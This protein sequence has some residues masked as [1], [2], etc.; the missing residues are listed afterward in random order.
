MLCSSFNSNVLY[1]KD[2]VKSETWKLCKYLCSPL[3][4]TLLG[5]R[6][7]GE[8]GFSKLSSTCTLWTEKSARPLGLKSVIVF[9]WHLHRCFSWALTFALLPTGEAKGTL[10]FPKFGMLSKK[11]N[12]LFYWRMPFLASSLR[13]KFAFTFHQIHFYPHA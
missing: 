4:W 2:G 11:E 5:K 3:Q 6:T 10:H 9:I 8:G 7:S 1:H 12:G 13:T